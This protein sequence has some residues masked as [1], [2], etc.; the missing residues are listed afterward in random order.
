MVSLICFPEKTWSGFCFLHS[1]LHRE[2]MSNFWVD[3]RHCPFFWVEYRRFCFI[4]L[5][6]LNQG[7]EGNVFIVLGLLFG[8][9]I[10]TLVWESQSVSLSISQALESL[11]CTTTSYLCEAGTWIQGSIN[12]LGK[13]STEWASPPVLYV[14]KKKEWLFP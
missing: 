12:I 13:Q 3:N 8:E 11:K 2:G 7:Q 10:H 1:A 5:P 14:T 4:C 9:L 6:F